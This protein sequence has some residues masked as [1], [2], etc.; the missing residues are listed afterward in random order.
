MLGHLIAE[1]Y[2]VYVREE[3]L[4]GTED[5]R[6]DGEMEVV[7]QFGA[8]KLLDSGDASADSDVL[9][10]CGGSGE[11]RGGVNS[12]GDEMECGVP[13]HGDGSACVVR[14]HEDLS[15]VWRIFAPPSFPAFVGPRAA[16]G[17][18]HIAAHDPCADIVEAADGEIIVDAGRAAVLAHHALKGASGEEPIVHSHAANAERVFKALRRAGTV[19]VDGNTEGVDS[20]LCH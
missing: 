3:L 8:Q 5:G 17:S 19:S 10:V 14:Q 18:E 16:D 13:L 7:N 2:Q 1:F 6:R 20:D 4:A 12:I 15:V 9:S 11:L